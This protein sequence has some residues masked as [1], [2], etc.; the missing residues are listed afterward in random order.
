VVKT[1]SRFGILF[2]RKSVQSSFDEKVKGLVED[3][4]HVDESARYGF[5]L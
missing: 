3:L 4:L 5:S 1:I 2:Q